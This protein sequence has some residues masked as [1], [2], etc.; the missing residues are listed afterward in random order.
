MLSKDEKIPEQDVE[1]QV[2][3]LDLHAAH[4]HWEAGTIFVA[5]LPE[6]RV[7][8]YR[9]S[10]VL[11]I[12][13][14]PDLFAARGSRSLEVRP[15]APTGSATPAVSDGSGVYLV[16]EVPDALREPVWDTMDGATPPPLRITPGSRFKRTF[17]VSDTGKH[18]P[19]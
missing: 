5:R 7:K 11:W 3:L 2:I 18:M 12:A 17:P 10:P 4:P 15:H 16:L 1:L 19:C 14:L 13:S 8:K 6:A 9:A